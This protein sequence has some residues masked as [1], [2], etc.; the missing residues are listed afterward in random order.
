MNSNALD[1][2]RCVDE[3]TVVFI[4][5][6]LHC[7][8]QCSHLQCQSFLNFQE[9]LDIGMSNVTLRVRSGVKRSRVQIFLSAFSALAAFTATAAAAAFIPFARSQETGVI[10]KFIVFFFFII[11]SVIIFLV[12]LHQGQGIIRRLSGSHGT[13]PIKRFQQLSSHQRLAVTIAAI[14]GQVLIIRRR[15]RRGRGV[16]FHGWIG[17]FLELSR[18]ERWFCVRFLMFLDV[19]IPVVAQV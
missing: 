3:T 17:N 12:L 11:I 4:H 6:S 1:R 5:Q 13:L 18:V 14:H 8:I 10:Q 2:V 15:R 9:M 16:I 19:L 7:G